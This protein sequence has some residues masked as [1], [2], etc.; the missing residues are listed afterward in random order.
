VKPPNKLDGA[1]VLYWA[2]AEE[3]FFR[4]PCVDS[5]AS[6]IPIHGLAVARYDSGSFYRFSCDANWE[7]QNDSDHGGVDQALHAPSAQYDVGQVA[8]IRWEA[9]P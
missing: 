9:E 8:W 2:D 5:S 4:M 6:S 3:P 1:T 7:V